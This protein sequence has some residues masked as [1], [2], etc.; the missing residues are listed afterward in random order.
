M[1]PT[2]YNDTQNNNKKDYT[3]YNNTLSIVT[4]RIT[5]RI[6]SLSIKHTQYNGTQNNNKNTRTLD[7][8]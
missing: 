8:A 3:R 2:Q 7:A 5:I 4:L 6:T 1:K